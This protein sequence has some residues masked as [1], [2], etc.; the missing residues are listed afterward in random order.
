MNKHNLLYISAIF[1]LVTMLFLLLNK[2]KQVEAVEEHVTDTLVVTKVDTIVEY[3]FVEKTKRVVDTIYIENKTP[4]EPFVA[5]LSEQKHYSK[6]NLY[7]IY[8]SGYKAK[9]DSIKIY[10][11]IEYRTI[12]KEIEITKWNYYGYIGLNNIG[13]SFNPNFGF[14]AQS[15][16]KWI[17]GCELGLYNNN[18][19][20]YGAK[21]GYKLNK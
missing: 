5:V 17:F 4:N 6:P 19:F 21:I 14:L 12:T 11:T 16:K 8:L 20:Y 2:D 3:R 18:K 13:G 15:K 9:L 7:D 10:P 1:V